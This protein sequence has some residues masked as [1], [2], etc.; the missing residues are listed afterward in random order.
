[1]QDTSLHRKAAQKLNGNK[2]A[3][4]LV[5]PPPPRLVPLSHQDT[6]SLTLDA[7]LVS[8]NTQASLEAQYPEDDAAHAERMA[9][10]EA[11]KKAVLQSLE[12]TTSQMR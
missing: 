5:T 2:L 8:T 3:L 1:M 12:L 10:L 9:R 4:R 6:I 7:G 11:T